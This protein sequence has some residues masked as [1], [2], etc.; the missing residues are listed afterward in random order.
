M[1]STIDLGELPAIMLGFIALA[2]ATWD[3]ARDSYFCWGE[4]GLTPTQV[5]RTG[6]E[7]APRAP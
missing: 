5:L 7:S 6:E 1:T 4:K 3:H 2:I